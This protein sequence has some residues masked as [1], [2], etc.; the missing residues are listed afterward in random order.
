[1]M[2][3]FNQSS[4]TSM[5]FS[6]GSSTFAPGTGGFTYN[7]SPYVHALNRA[8]QL[9]Q[10]AIAVYA[11]RQRGAGPIAACRERTGCHHH[12]LRE[13]VRMIFAQRAIPD[14]DPATFMAV[15]STLAARAARWMP[16]PVKLPVLEI[17]SQRIE[18]SLFRRYEKLVKIAPPSDLAV[19]KNL[20]EQTRDFCDESL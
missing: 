3:M 13:L 9:E 11:A 14:S 2:P 19:I 7:E 8:L 18:I 20:L 6:L 10:A 5:L 12:A 17:S 4:R 16:Q 15:T 1:M